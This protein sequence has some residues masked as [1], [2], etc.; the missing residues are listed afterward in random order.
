MIPAPYNLPTG[1]RGDSY[2]QITFFLTNVSGSGIYIDGASGAAQVKNKRGQVALE[3]LTSDDSMLIS[4]NSVT[5]K[6][7]CGDQMRV[8]P[9]I[10]LWDLEVSSGC[11]TNTYLSGEFKIIEDITEI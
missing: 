2:K 3:W 10:Y 5:L 8:N 7:K 1:Y 11:L 9:D 6:A 4:G